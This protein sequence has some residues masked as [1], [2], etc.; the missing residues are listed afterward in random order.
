MRIDDGP[1]Q[2]DEYAAKRSVK[3]IYGVVF[4]L[5]GLVV[6]FWLPADQQWIRLGLGFV[7]V[8]L[9]GVMIDPSAVRFWIEVLKDLRP[10]IGG[11]TP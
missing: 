8:L 10:M 4:A 3:A 9:G 5:L 11:K 7:L 2:R 1:T 6:M